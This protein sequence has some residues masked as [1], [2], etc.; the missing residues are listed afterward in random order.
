VVGFSE[1]PNAERTLFVIA[2]AESSF[3]PVP[4][5]VLLIPLAIGNPRRALRFAALCTVGSSLGALLGY[6]LGLEF[7]EL[8]GRPIVEFYAVG[9][10]YER[11][12]VLY[13]QWDAVAIAVAGFTPIPFKIFTI[14]AGLFEINLITFVVVVVLSR[15][16]RFFL[17]G[18]LIW[19]FGPSIQNFVDRYF[20][21]LVILFSI[22]LVGGFLS[23]KYVL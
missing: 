16:A 1:R 8:I 3:F 15:G 20:N 19:W 9:E 11:V 10:Q 18:G 4:P 6:W 22:L 2:F 17:L 12:Q 23:L 13:Q 21:L 7:Y 5:D 14:A